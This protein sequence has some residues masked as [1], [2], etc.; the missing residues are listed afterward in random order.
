MYIDSEIGDVQVGGRKLLTND[1]IP[2]PTAA[3]AGKVL[4]ASAAGKAGWTA[5]TNAEEVAY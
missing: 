3:D 2:L 4:T 1:N 5:V